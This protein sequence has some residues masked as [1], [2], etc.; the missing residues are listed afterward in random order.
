[1]KNPGFKVNEHVLYQ[2]G[3]SFEIG[4][5][6][7]LCDDG[8]FVWYHEG[9]TAAKTPYECL[10]PLVNRHCIVCTSLGRGSEF[11]MKAINAL[12]DMDEEDENEQ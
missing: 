2:N 5:V 8:A 10:H 7:R 1:M 9:E 6:K 11:F 3:D 12:E 4:R